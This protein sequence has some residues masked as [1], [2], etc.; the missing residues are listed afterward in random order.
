MNDSNPTSGNDTGIPHKPVSYHQNT[1]H[2][3]LVLCAP[4]VFQGAISKIEALRRKQAEYI[5]TLPTDPAIQIG[6]A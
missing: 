1:E 3:G 4:V 2:H 5:K 6:A